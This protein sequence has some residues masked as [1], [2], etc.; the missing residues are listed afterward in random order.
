MRLARKRH[1]LGDVHT[2]N[3]PVGGCLAESSIN[4]F[5]LNCG[6]C[7]LQRHKI[8]SVTFKCYKTQWLKDR[9]K[10][11]LRHFPVSKILIASF[12]SQNKL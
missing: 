4:D 1:G 9:L 5:K 2:H 3:L 6:K 8:V 10:K 7:D 11:L 12:Q